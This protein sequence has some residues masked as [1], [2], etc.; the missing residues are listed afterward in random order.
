MLKG[1]KAKLALLGVV[2]GSIAVPFSAW[3]QYV[4]PQTEVDNQSANSPYR[5]DFQVTGPDKARPVQVFSDGSQTFIQFPPGIKPSYAKYDGAKDRFHETSPYYVLYGAPNEF[6]VVTNKG[7][8]NIRAMNN[9]NDAASLLPPKPKPV[10]T[11]SDLE[12]RFDKPVE[13]EKIEAALKYAQ[14]A[15]EKAK[16][17]VNAQKSG[18]TY[19]GPGGGP[20]PSVTVTTAE[21]TKA[22]LEHEQKIKTLNPGGRLSDELRKYVKAMGW[23]D[24]KWNLDYDYKITAPIPMK[25]DMI[26]AVTNLVKTYQDQGGLM[27]VTPFFAAGNRTVVIQKMD[28]AAPMPSVTK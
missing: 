11:N 20:R 3:A 9:E 10:I 7:S 14:S 5:F 21:V 1:K 28:L 23:S 18:T 15:V 8:I 12:N 17:A 19:Y 16:T 6:I 26:T 27:G 2:I 22:R 4:A 24:L 13:R 25:G